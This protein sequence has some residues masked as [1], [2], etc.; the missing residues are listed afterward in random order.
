MHI[1]TL[2]PEVLKRVCRYAWK[3][4]LIG[5]LQLLIFPFAMVAVHRWG[6][7][8]CVL[9]WLDW[10]AVPGGLLVALSVFIWSLM[11]AT[12]IAI[13]RIAKVNLL[14]ETEEDYWDWDLLMFDSPE[15]SDDLSQ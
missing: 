3:L 12:R 10:L 1:R 2:S 4:R 6:W 14:E 9:R 15:F 5:F 11:N 8:F 7:D 13:K